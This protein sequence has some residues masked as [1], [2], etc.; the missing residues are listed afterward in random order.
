MILR[1]LSSTVMHL[2]LQMFPSRASQKS[3][4]V[5][6]M[7][8]LHTKFWILDMCKSKFLLLMIYRS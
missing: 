8:G 2:S 5:Y 4:N 7:A 1:T 6:K 3:W